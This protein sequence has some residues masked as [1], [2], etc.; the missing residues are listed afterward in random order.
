MNQNSVVK[1][2]V[3]GEGFHQHEAVPVNDSTN[4]I[5]QGDFTYFDDVAGIA[6]PV[7]TDAH[8]ANLLGVALKPSKV[9]GSID[10]SSE[11]DITVG[12]GHID[13]K[14]TTPG[15]TYAN[16]TKVY[17]GATP[18]TIT[19]VAGSNPVGTVRL[20]SGSGPVTGAAGKQV[21]LIAYSRKW[22]SLHE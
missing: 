20:P 13:Q 3:N 18:Q 8:A 2:S 22:V 19:T 15:E 7:D 1:G 4:H 16:G 21:Q 11:P 12:Y 9:S 10:V 6:K 5:D 17:I 14:F